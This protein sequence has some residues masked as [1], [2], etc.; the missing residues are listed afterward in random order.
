MNLRIV[1]GNLKKS[2]HLGGGKVVKV[3]TGLSW[4]RMGLDGRLVNTV[5]VLWFA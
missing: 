4:L 3:W 2:S 1:V 5:V